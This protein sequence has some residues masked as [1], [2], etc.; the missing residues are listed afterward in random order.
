MSSFRVN[1]ANSIIN[2]QGNLGIGTL[3]P[4][5][6][7]AL[8][9][10]STNTLLSLSQLGSGLA[11]NVISGLSVFGGNVTVSGAFTVTGG[12]SFSGGANTYWHSGN[13]GS[14]SGLDAD[15][16]DGNNSSFFSNAFNMTTGT[17]P[18]ARLAGSYTGISA[19]GVLTDLDVTGNVSVDT[20]TF[21][22]DSV[23]NKVGIGKTNPQ[24][25]LD[26]AGSANISGT[27]S[28]GLGSE[29]APAYSFSTL[30][31]GQR[32]SNTYLAVVVNGRDA[33]RL[34]DLAGV[35]RFDLLSSNSSAALYR[36]SFDGTPVSNNT[37]L[38]YDIHTGR[39]SANTVVEFE[40]EWIRA[41]N[42][43][44]AIEVGQKNWNVTSQGISTQ[45]MS[46]TGAGV[47]VSAYPTLQ[48][49]SDTR[50]QA[51]VGNVAIPGVGFV[52]DPDSGLYSIG[53]NQL[54]ISVGGTHTVNVKVGSVEITGRL[55]TSSNMSVT[56][57][58][59]VSGPIYSG[60]N[61]VWH[62]GTL[63]LGSNTAWHSGNDGAG[64]QLDAGLLGGQPP[65]YYV[66][67]NNFT[68]GTVPSARM[69]GLYSNM[70][71][72]M[73]VRMS[74][75]TISMMNTVMQNFT[76]QITNIG[77]TIKH[78]I[79]RVGSPAGSTALASKIIG[80]N[81]TI[82]DTELGND[83]TKAITNGMKVSS[84][85]KNVLIFNT[86][87]QAAHTDYFY[88]IAVLTKPNKDTVPLRNT[89]IGTTSRDVN[90][91]T[92]RRLEC[93]LYMANGDAWNVTTDNLATGEQVLITIMASLI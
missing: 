49:L 52:G 26:V 40:R 13:D 87:D 78:K 79:G 53:D 32:A 77:G 69:N 74:S 29:Q 48:M 39:N 80:A 18:P 56:G 92:I 62:S 76:I 34:Y 8:A 27:L 28:V 81:T 23:G 72:N 31:H 93:E 85:E 24:N 73:A 7:V 90:G 20:S 71:A 55:N 42:S 1:G 50:L 4:N 67:A 86:A 84:V 45:V 33:F 36:S 51:N 25:A 88:G 21:F 75:N 3:T 17:L 22:V 43:S 10:N 35:S 11:L 68:A 63:D 60:A 82:N 58:M 30:K 38:S 2:S 9:G 59:N 83:L 41:V 65:G 57:R 15:L 6:N 44:S 5:A 14:G 47:T 64:S 66:D 19:L 16:L 12:I 37:I 54:G 61:T 89:N 70:T 46:L 91:T